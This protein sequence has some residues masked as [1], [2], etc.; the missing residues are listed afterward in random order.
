M[1]LDESTG[2]GA[3]EAAARPGK[4]QDKARNRGEITGAL[5]MSDKEK[6][7]YERP[8][9]VDHGSRREN[10]RTGTEEAAA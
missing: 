10:T 7:N 1:T 2:A 8:V 6:G 4:R 9:S 3:E 5:A